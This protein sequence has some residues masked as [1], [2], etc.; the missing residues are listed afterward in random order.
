MSA[1]TS[2]IVY[3]KTVFMQFLYMVKHQLI[4]NYSNVNLQQ[5]STSKATFVLR[6]CLKKAEKGE[7]TSVLKFLSLVLNSLVQ[8]PTNM[9][10][11]N[12]FAWT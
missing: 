8:W 7:I 3:C 10:V 11:M 1:D 9:L 2:D 6:L 12:D 4:I 5:L